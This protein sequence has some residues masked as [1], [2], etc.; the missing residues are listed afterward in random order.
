MAE[1]RKPRIALMGEFS[2]GKST[3][4]NL[5]LGSRP[6]PEKVTAT[7]L[8]PVWM[9]YGTQAPYR[10]AMDGSTE[11]VS[12]DALEDIPVDE[13]RVIR[14]F[15]DADILDV[16]DLI[17]FPGISDPN[18][19]S[20]VWER[21]LPE[22]DAVIWCTH[23]TQAWRQSE[24]AVWET[25]PEPVREHSILL[26]TR[27][28]KL[29]TDKDRRRVFKRVR[30]E[31]DGQF[32]GTF[33]ISLLQALE[34]GDDYDKWDGSGAGPFVDHLLETIQKLSTLAARSPQPLYN[35]TGD[36]AVPEPAAPPV[37][38][39]RVTRMIDPD[40]PKRSRPPSRPSEDLNK[41]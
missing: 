5:L 29:T 8:S 26:I 25:M 24:A 4:S 33:P 28:D 31:T 10:E 1:P 9:S 30:R 3:L 11:P 12:L 37:A 41:S 34:A 27:Y 2:A 32:G 40:Q 6:L 17:D 14:L 36:N 18:M 23:A 13:T 16:I 39:R 21:V 15:L 35:I 19:A 38:P 22:V 7:R 20:T